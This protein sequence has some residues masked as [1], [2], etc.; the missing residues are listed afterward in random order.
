MSLVLNHVNLVVTDPDRSAAFYQ[1]HFGMTEQWRE[2]DFV[3]LRSGET[4]FALVAGRPVF[5]K[6]FHVGFRLESRDAVEALLARMRDA[7]IQVSYGPKDYGDYYTF[8]CRDPD[9]YGIEIYFE[10][11]PRGRVGFPDR[12]DN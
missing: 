8:T 1:Q 3:F 4:D 2:G 6:S 10:T 9:G 7:D 5:H 11:E 12:S